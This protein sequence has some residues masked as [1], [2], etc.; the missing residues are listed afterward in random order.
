[1]TV[2]TSTSV[3]CSG[4]FQTPIMEFFW[5]TVD[6]ILKKSIEKNDFFVNSNTF[7]VEGNGN[8][9]KKI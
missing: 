3:A 4:P 9:K 6:R 7:F 2:L 8:T 5:R 1:M